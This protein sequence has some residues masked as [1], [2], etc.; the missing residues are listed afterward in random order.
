VGSRSL[1]LSFLATIASPQQTPRITFDGAAEML[2]TLGMQQGGFQFRRLAGAFQRIFGATIYF[3]TDTYRECAVVAPRARFNFMSEAQVEVC[4]EGGIKGGQEADGEFS[5]RCT[6]H[7]VQKVSD[8]P[9]CYA[10]G[11][12]TDHQQLRQH[13]HQEFRL[14]IRRSGVIVPIPLAHR[15][16]LERSTCLAASEQ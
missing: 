5:L 4:V 12:S 7:H 3:V 9:D 15:R 8:A 2:D 16:G 13:V 1:V 10:F 11:V 14:L 6:L